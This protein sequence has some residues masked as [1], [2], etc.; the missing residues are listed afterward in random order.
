MKGAH[1]CKWPACN[2]MRQITGICTTHRRRR[3]A[4]LK[5]WGQRAQQSPWRFEDRPT[6][7]PLGRRI[8]AVD[9]S[10]QYTNAGRVPQL[11]A[12][13]LDNGRRIYFAVYETENGDYVVRGHITATRRK[14]RKDRA[15]TQTG[16]WPWCKACQSWHHP[17]NPTCFKITGQKARMRRA[18]RKQAAR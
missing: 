11:D 9:Q 17:D 16:S 10:M 15:T 1:F 14:D 3:N 6:W 8:V 13:V 5:R 7:S 12:L 4:I 18:D 2:A